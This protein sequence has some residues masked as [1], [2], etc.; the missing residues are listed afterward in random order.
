MKKSVKLNILSAKKRGSMVL[1][2]APEQ[3]GVDIAVTNH[4]LKKEKK[5]VK[6]LLERIKENRKN[7]LQSQKNMAGIR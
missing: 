4:G 3:R 5:K 1:D 7:K 6:T 2:R